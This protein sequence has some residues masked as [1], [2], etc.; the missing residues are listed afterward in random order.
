MKKGTKDTVITI[1]ASVAIV[2]VVFSGL[3]AYSG[4]WPPFSVVES[5]S[6]QHSDRSSFSTIDTGDAVVVRSPDKVTIRT[7]VDGYKE[8]YKKFGDYGDVI[9]YE[10][11]GMN[12]VIHRAVIWL[13]WNSTSWEALSLEGFP[14]ENWYND[15]NTDYR[16][17]TGTL[18]FYNYGFSSQTVHLNLD[19]L[20]EVSGYV[21]KGDNNPVFDNAPT[22]LVPG[23]IS[24][25][26]IL[27]V[28]GFS[29]P[30]LGIIKFYISGDQDVISRIPANS[31]PEMIAMT[32]AVISV[33][34]AL[35][36]ITEYISW[37]RRKDG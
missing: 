15:G 35:F 17:L 27:Y 9:V 11:P 13:D 8:G 37:Y 34:V 4:I 3:Y 36:V 19:L 5:G 22:G 16:N 10:R 18:T 12:P 14:T 29:I 32:V 7:Y 28:A 1:A 25:E 2:A 20:P 6:M 21:T 23:L 31:V 30:W 33:F 24:E 26:K